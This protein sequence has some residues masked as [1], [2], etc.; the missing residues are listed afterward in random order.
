MDR[1][2]CC[3]FVVDWKKWDNWLVQI[4]LK[5]NKIDW[6]KQKNKLVE[7]R[8]MG[9]EKSEG[10]REKK[11]NLQ[12]N[13]HTHTHRKKHWKK[14]CNHYHHFFLVSCNNNNN[15]K[16][17]NSMKKNENQKKT[18]KK[19]LDDYLL[20]TKI[21]NGWKLQS[22]NQWMNQWEKNTTQGKI[23]YITVWIQ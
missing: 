13:K 7:I 19:R 11:P 4:K 8:K 5:Q 21:T 16:R 1:L 20:K 23:S 3:L 6:L 12:K 15:T 9:N 2:C 14:T 17:T 10:V 22:I 18:R